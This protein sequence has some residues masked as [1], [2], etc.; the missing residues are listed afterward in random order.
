[1]A[2]K[3]ERRSAPPATA[4]WRDPRVR[5][6]FFQAVVLGIVLLV[7]AY[8]INN[9]FVNRERLGI[10]AGFGFLEA[11]AGFGIS[12]A[13]IPYQ[14]ADTFGW[15]FIVG[16]VNTIYVAVIGIVLATIIGFAMGI[17]RLSNNALVRGVASTYV[18][19]VRN[20]PLLLQIIFVYAVIIPLMPHPRDSINPLPGVFINNRGMF[21]PEPNFLPGSEWIA[22]ALGIGVI[23]TWWVL[24]SA[25]IRFEQTGQP[26]PVLLP[27]L[28]L[29]VGLPAVAFLIAD[30]PVEIVFPAANRFRIQGGLS[31]KPEF[32]ALLA[33]L[34]LYTGAFIAEIVRSGILSVSKGQREAA[35]ALGLS[36]AVTLRKIIIPQ[37]LR[38]II[39][40]QTNQYLNLTKNSSLAVAIGYPDLF[41]VGG[42]INNQTGQAVEVIT[43]IMAVYLTLSL[44]TSLAMNTYN[45]RM[46]LKER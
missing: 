32:L 1:M 41:S 2:L 7:G 4:F 12:Q 29:L 33:A 16:V 25:R 43:M 44:L 8:L 15:A 10:N 28:G 39:P 36:T 17:A 46:A 20:I 21:F 31:F 37:A 40:P 42:T 23:G 11:T 6:I 38:V 30:S 45:S 34:S 14:D 24:R 27:I 13:L 18:E 19:V 5:G 35:R 3:L 9:T 26:R 22:L